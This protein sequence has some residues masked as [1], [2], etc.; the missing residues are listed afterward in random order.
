M[1]LNPTSVQV[2]C[3][4]PPK[5][6]LCPI[7]MEIQKYVDTVTLFSNLPPKLMTPWWPLSQLLLTS[8]VWLYYIKGSLCPSPMGI[9]QCMWIQWSILQNFDQD[10]TYYL[11]T[12]TCTYRMSDHTVSLG[13]K[14]RQ[15]NKS[16]RPFKLN[17]E[18]LHHSNMH[19][20]IVLS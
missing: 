13:T 14:F 1:T 12:Y 19:S 10:T 7:P 15:G 17:P 16:T 18:S 3:A 6:S 5:E 4:T 11:H 20:D 8:N 9:H 2:T